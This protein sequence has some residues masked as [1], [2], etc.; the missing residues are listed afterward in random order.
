LLKLQ[1]LYV[2]GLIK[3]SKKY[4]IVA[5]FFFQL[6]CQLYAAYDFVVILRSV[7][8]GVFFYISLF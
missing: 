4:E 1:H 7:L 6:E 8:F 5:G 2:F 3:L